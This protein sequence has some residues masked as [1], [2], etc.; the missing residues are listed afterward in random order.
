MTKWTFTGRFPNDALY[1]VSEGPGEIAKMVH[2]TVTRNEYID[3]METPA[4]PR[5]GSELSQG[6]TEEPIYHVLEGP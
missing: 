1:H 3:P 2:C 4:K 6:S 5:P